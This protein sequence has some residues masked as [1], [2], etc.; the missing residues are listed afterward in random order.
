MRSAERECLRLRLPGDQ[1]LECTGDHPLYD[2]DAEVTGFHGRFAIFDAPVGPVSINVGY[3]VEDIPYYEAWYY[4]Y[5]P[6]GG[7]T[8]LYPVWVELF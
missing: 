1:A 2:P 4:T 6:E 5:V 7:V 3:W 8:P